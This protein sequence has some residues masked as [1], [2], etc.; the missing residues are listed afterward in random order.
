[1]KKDKRENKMSPEQLQD[2]L[3]FRKRGYVQ[4]NKKAYN[5]KEKHKNNFKKD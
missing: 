5:R 2:F 3:H 1:M 4:K